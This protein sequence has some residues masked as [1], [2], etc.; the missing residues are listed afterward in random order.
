MRK[1]LFP[2]VLSTLIACNGKGSNQGNQPC[3][4]A[5]PAS[6]DPA[7]IPVDSANKM[8]SSYLNSIKYQTNDT[9]LKS[10]ILDANALRSVL[11]DPRGQNISHLKVMFGH[12]LNYINA[13]GENQPCG[14]K[15]GA[16]TI[17][18]AGYD[19]QGNYI[20]CPLG[21]ILDNAMPCPAACP[22]GQ[23]GQDLLPQ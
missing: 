21:N 20:Y 22:S 14:Y 18:L 7:Y 17:I 5:A 9:D 8:I 11:M 12:T 19:N 3:N 13:G 10:L 23:A 1:I 2:I 4:V 15:S 16:L 6:G